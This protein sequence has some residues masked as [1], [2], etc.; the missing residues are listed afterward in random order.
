MT[1]KILSREGG[2]PLLSI[3]LFKAVIQLLLLFGADSCA[4]TP[5]MGLVLGVFLYQMA[6][7]LTVQLLQRRADRK[8]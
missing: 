2:D 8:W 6:Q 4:I 5:C 1:M 7:Q 3:F